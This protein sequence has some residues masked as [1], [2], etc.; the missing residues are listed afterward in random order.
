MRIA[1][2]MSGGLP[3]G[4]SAMPDGHDLDDWHQRKIREWLLLLLRFVITRDPRDEAAVFA[5]ADEI[6]A[7]GLHWRPTAPG[8]FLRTSTELC[9]VIADPQSPRRT[10]VLRKHARRI[11]DRRLRQAFQAA[12]SVD[13]PAVRSERA[14]LKRSDLWK[15]LKGS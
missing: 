2:S 8:F 14:G 4:A 1:A 11:D 10:W 12:V 6:D 5:M 9:T 3:S 13:S 15:G 7:I